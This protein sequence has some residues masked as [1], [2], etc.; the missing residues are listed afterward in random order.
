MPDFQAARHMVELIAARKVPPEIMRQAALGTLSL[1]AADRLALLVYLAQGDF[2]CRASASETLA[3]TDQA[4]VE[5]LLSRP[6][7][8]AFLR[9]VAIQDAKAVA[10]TTS[11]AEGE[12]LSPE[13][14]ALLAAAAEETEPFQL[15][16]ASEEEQAALAPSPAAGVPTSEN[17]LARIAKMSVA[18]RTRRALLGNR[19]ERL[20]L[21]RDSNKVVQRGVMNSPR[22]TESDVELIAAMRNV[23]DEVLRMIGKSRRWRQSMAIIRTLVKNPRT[24]IEIGLDLVKHL[25]P[26]DLRQLAANKNVNEMLRRTANKLMQQRQG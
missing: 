4:A 7:C 15:V 10:E 18:E 1:P 19:D 3:K 24:P 25:F 16:E 17:L 8:P 23:S 14:Q 12:P 26:N 21:V 6:D 2:D 5:A 9:P 13:Q 11:E 20:L 22:L